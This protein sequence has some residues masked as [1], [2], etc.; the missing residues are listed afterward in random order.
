MMAILTLVGGK[1][2]PG[3]VLVL[4][5]SYEQPLSFAEWLFIGKC[6]LD[7]EDVYYPVSGG[8]IGKAMLLNALH[9]LACGVPF[10]RVL[11]RYGLK[12]KAGLSIVDKRKNVL[13]ASVR[14]ER[15]SELLRNEGR[16]YVSAIL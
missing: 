6:Y 7:S 1:K 15:V 4:V 5:T 11:E 10:D 8:Y 13:G 12:R 2:G 14:L 16:D 9:E 3:D